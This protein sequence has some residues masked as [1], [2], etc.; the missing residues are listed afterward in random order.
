MMPLVGSSPLPGFGDF[1]GHVWLNTAHQGALPLAAAEAARDAIAWKTM[2]FALTQARFEDVPM[3][4]RTA[5]GQIVNAPAEEIILANSAS[6][7]LHLIASAYPWSEGDEILVMRGDFPSDILPWLL[8]EQRHGVKVICINPRGRVVEPDELKAAIT[9]RTR[10]FCTSWVHSFSGFAVDADALG[11][12]C[13]EHGV[14]FILNGS[15]A[16]GARPLDLAVACIDAFISV[17][18]KWLCGP[19]GTGFAW[20][21]SEF[22]EQLRPTKAYWL[23][24]QT[25]EDLAMEITETE[26]R[27]ISGA[28]AYDVFG[29]ANFFNFVPFA[30]AVEHLTTLGLERVRDHDEMLVSHFVEGIDRAMY[31]VTSPND[32]SPQRS[33]LIFFSHNDRDKNR[34][35]YETLVRANLHVG[36]RDGCLRLAPHLYN[37]VNDINRTLNALHDFG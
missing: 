25:A 14:R 1:A 24:M 11:A 8:L 26:L 12:I 31:R 20:I 37:T 34:V 35:I 17:G 10:L 29:T 28:R 30:T 2:P 6:Y 9:P 16:L 22:R 19:Y 4:L 7:G 3:R 5:L 21:R 36:F 23:A 33:T 32:R 18:F 27:E 15:Q 13:R